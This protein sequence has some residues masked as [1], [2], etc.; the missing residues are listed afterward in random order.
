[1]QFQ[2]SHSTLNARMYL[3]DTPRDIMAKDPMLQSLCSTSTWNAQELMPYISNYIVMCSR[4]LCSTQNLSTHVL[5]NF[6]LNTNISSIMCF[7]VHAQHK[8]FINHVLQGPH[9]TQNIYIPIYHQQLAY[10][11]Y[12]KQI[13]MLICSGVFDPI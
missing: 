7:T 5:Q 1:M 12:T 13:S 8:H 6:S 9:P 4:A 2:T 11:Q 3:Y 10:T